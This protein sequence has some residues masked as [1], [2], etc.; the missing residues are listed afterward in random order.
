M[1]NK[2]ALTISLVGLI[3]LIATCVLTSSKGRLSGTTLESREAILQSQPGQYPWKILD[4]QVVDGYLVCSMREDPEI[5]IQDNEIGIAIFE[6]LEDGKHSFVTWAKRESEEIVFSHVRF[7]ENEYV[8]IF[9]DIP[10]PSHAEVTFI[11][12]DTV[13]ESK[14]HELTENRV[15]VL[16]R[17]EDPLT[18][19]AIYYDINGNKYE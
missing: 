14:T 10:S 4:E 16:P 9:A 11:R 7:H 19:T 1:R 18:V 5:G 2:I 15:L 17:P 12:D 6:I 13:L 3:V 8:L